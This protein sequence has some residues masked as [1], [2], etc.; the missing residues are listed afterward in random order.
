[1][2]GLRR[3]LLA[4]VLAAAVWCAPVAASERPLVVAVNYPLAFFAERLGKGEADILLPVP[5]GADPAFWRPAIAAIGRIQNA[6]L[7]LLNGA[8]FARW[9][10]R[11]SLPR[12]RVVETARGFEDRFIATESVTHSHGPDGE[13]TH[14]GTA[15]FT[16]LDPQQA[17]LQARAVAEALAVRGIVPEGAVDERLAALVDDLARLDAAARRLEAHAGDVV[18]IATHPRYQYLARAY[19]LDIRAVEWEAGAAPGAAELARLDA[20]ARESGARILLWEA[21]PPR[22]ARKAVRDLGLADVVFPTLSTPPADGDY[23]TAFEAAVE[24]LLAA[25]AGL[26]GG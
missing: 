13:H 8:G 23:V 6:D 9:T 15:S 4:L 7:I 5:E 26:T 18:L 22:E 14:T 3:P 12:A 24:A 16:W 25:M 10:E 2:P 19:G 11:V 20:L 17:I 1:M 21:E